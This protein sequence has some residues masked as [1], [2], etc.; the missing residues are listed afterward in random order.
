MA[1]PK[2]PHKTPEDQSIHHIRTCTS[3]E[4]LRAYMDAMKAEMI[5]V[6]ADDRVTEAARVKWRELE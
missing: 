1:R 6:W 4:E 2:T 5:S 3:R